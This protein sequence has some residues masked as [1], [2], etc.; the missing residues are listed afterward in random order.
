[1]VTLS[2]PNYISPNQVPSSSPFSKKE[3]SAIP[4][5]N[6]LAATRRPFDDPNHLALQRLGCQL[7]IRTIMREILRGYQSLQLLSR[8]KVFRIPGTTQLAHTGSNQASC[9][10]LAQLGQFIFHCGNP[11]TQFQF[12]RWPELY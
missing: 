6:S 7:L 2:E 1:M 5:G 8:H 10:A 3:F 9:M 4:S 12:S 11:V